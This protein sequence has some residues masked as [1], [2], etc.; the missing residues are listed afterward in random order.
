VSLWPYAMKVPS[1]VR[2][3]TLSV[4]MDVPPYELFYGTKPDVSMLR[5]LGV[6]PKY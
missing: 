6:P 2:N 3:R 1:Y 4:G 5:S